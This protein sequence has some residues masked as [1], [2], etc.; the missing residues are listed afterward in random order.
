[1]KHKQLIEMLEDVGVYSWKSREAQKNNRNNNYYARIT[2]INS[3]K[4]SKMWLERCYIYMV[5]HNL[6]EKMNWRDVYEF[7]KN[8]YHFTKQEHLK[9]FKKE[10]TH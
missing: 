7:Q 6:Y 10:K 8:F 9:K 5:F 3:L 2:S 1:M 4:M